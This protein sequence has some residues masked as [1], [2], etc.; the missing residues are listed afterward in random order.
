MNHWA[1]GLRI[2]GWPP[3][4][5]EDT[6]NATCPA[7]IL[8]FRD[9]PLSCTV[10]STWLYPGGIVLISITKYWTSSSSRH[11]Q[12]GTESSR[13]HWPV[14]IELH[15]SKDSPTRLGTLLSCLSSTANDR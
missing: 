14:L 6:S 11:P 2:L 4:S 8:Q 15:N 10:T 1:D 12:C 3:G 5:F 7:T 13:E 9:V